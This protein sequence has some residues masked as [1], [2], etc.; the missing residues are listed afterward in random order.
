MYDRPSRNGACEIFILQKTH[1]T[2]DNMEESTII[3]DMYAVEKSTGKVVAGNKQS[4]GQRVQRN[5]EGLRVSK[6]SN[7]QGID[8][9]IHH[10]FQSYYS[11]GKS[12]TSK[13]NT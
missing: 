2:E 10:I 4:W 12:R 1:Y 7:I 6:S 9:G 11:V 13:N 3:L 5:T 8:P